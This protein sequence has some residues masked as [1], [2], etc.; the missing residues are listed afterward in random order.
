MLEQTVGSTEPKKGYRWG[1]IAILAG[2]GFAVY[3]WGMASINYITGY[4]NTRCLEFFEKTGT[5]PAFDPDPSDPKLFVADTYIRNGEVV[6]EVAQK[7]KKDGKEG[8][9]QTRLC[10]VNSKSV[11]IPGLFEQWQYR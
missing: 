2:L 3:Y 10:V 8:Y 11:Q 1:R 9:M 6:V 4:A 7:T 5:K